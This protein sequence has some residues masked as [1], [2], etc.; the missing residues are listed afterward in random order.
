MTP[1]YEYISAGNQNRYRGLVDEAPLG[2][3]VPLVR[4]FH[5]LH[6]RHVSGLRVWNREDGERDR[7][8]EDGERDRE[9]GER[10]RE[11]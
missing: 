5:P 8:R 1:N 10:D 11:E 3:A 2:L 9:D 6:R 4:Y 7:D